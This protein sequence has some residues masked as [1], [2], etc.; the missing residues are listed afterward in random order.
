LFKLCIVAS[1][2]L[3]TVG[4]QLV[5]GTYSCPV[6]ST[7]IYTNNPNNP[8]PDIKNHVFNCMTNNGS[9]INS[10]YNFPNSYNTGLLL[11]ILGST[12]GL[13]IVSII[14]VAFYYVYIKH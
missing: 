4:G 6:N 11:I 9:I 1:I 3:G 8:T 2:A 7:Q 5:T 14:I 12:L 10:V 13:F